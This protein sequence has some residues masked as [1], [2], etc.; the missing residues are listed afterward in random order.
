M[1]LTI[2]FTLLFA[3]TTATAS[4]QIYPSGIQY[5]GTGNLSVTISVYNPDDEAVKAELVLVK[6]LRQNP[7]DDIEIKSIVLQQRGD[8]RIPVIFDIKAD[9][10]PFWL[11]VKSFQGTQAVRDCS[12]IHQR[13]MK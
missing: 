7:K 13:K 6:D 9:P 2:L 1:K 3:I 8:K 12:T 10:K 5:M 4:P 11:C